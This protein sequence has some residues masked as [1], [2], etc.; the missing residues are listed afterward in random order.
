M[1]CAPDNVN[2]L[3]SVVQRWRE[4]TAI[5]L[6]LEP[7]GHKVP[8]A[9][10]VRGCS[11][12]CRLRELQ[13]R[14]HRLLHSGVIAWVRAS[15]NMLGASCLQGR[16]AP[17]PDQE[18]ASCEAKFLTVPH[19]LSSPSCW[20]SVALLRRVTTACAADRTPATGV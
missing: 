3:K 7:Y 6:N 2:L 9:E 17:E 16:K 4:A 8:L 1:R 13:I 15:H 19:L 11:G 5:L 12:T 14:G 10:Q 20:P 18:P